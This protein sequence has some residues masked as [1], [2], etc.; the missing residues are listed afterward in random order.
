MQD[1]ARLQNRSAVQY[2]PETPHSEK[3]ASPGA[4]AT[5]S[6]MARTIPMLAIALIFANLA[7]AAVGGLYLSRFPRGGI[8][9]LHVSTC[10]CDKCPPQAPLNQ[11]P[12][13]NSTIEVDQ[14]QKSSISSMI[15]SKGAVEGE[16][17]SLAP[18]LPIAAPEDEKVVAVLFFGVTRSIKY[19]LRSIQDNI[20]GSLK[21]AGYRVN[22][23]V[24]TYS[25]ESSSVDGASEGHENNEWQLLEPFK[26]SVTNQTEFLEAIRC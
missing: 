8:A 3:N 19:T 7:L 13:E 10:V 25:D 21:R 15:V 9:G 11:Q 2:R 12:P 18:N 23:F 16:E 26:V 14:S 4:A 17:A 6:R 1:W 5:P 20:V 24:H 22:V